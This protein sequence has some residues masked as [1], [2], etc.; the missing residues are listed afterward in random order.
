MD[1]SVTLRPVAQVEYVLPHL[2]DDKPRLTEVD[3]IKHKSAQRQTRLTAMQGHR[4]GMRLTIQLNA[5]AERTVVL[6][7]E[8][9][10]IAFVFGRREHAPAGAYVYV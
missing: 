9:R 2:L 5:A 7:V 10:C 8:I 1:N 6:A 3:G 4:D